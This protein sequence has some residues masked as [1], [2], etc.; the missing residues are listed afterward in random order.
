MRRTQQESEIY[1]EMVSK[2]GIQIITEYKGNA[3]ICTYS[4]VGYDQCIPVQSSCVDEDSLREVSQ[5]AMVKYKTSGLL[6]HNKS[7]LAACVQE[8]HGWTIDCE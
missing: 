8:Q 2:S 1:T 4:S 6:N 3:I 5:I 7:T